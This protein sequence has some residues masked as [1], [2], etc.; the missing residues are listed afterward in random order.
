MKPVREERTGW[1]CEKISQRHRHWGYNCPCVDLDF[2][3][4][5]YNHGKPVAVIEYKD[6][7]AG[8]PN[9]DHPTYKA[10]IALAD[11]YKGGPL[12]CAIVFYCSETWWFKVIPLNEKAKS[13]FGHVA[14]QKIPEQRFVRGLYLLRN[15][16]LSKEDEVAISKLNDKLVADP[17][18]QGES[19][20]PSRRSSQ[21]A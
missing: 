6:K 13:Y 4:V 11:G 8:E 20:S 10:L 17:T 3:V 18:T 21:A 15:K 12:P 2:V 19:V 7:H 1:R 16:T 5:E 9:I 14:N